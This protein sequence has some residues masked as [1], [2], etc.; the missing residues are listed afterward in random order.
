MGVLHLLPPGQHGG[1]VAGVLDRNAVA[2]RGGF[3]F[4]GRKRELGLL[5][6]AV[7][8]PPAVVLVEG[9]AGIGKSRL[10]HEATAALGAGEPVVLT[11]SC[12]PLR[13]PFPYGYGERQHGDQ[14]NRREHGQFLGDPH[15]ARPSRCRL[16]LGNAETRSARNGWMVA[17][18]SWRTIMCAVLVW[19]M[20][21]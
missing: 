16:P 14:R 7:R 8:R 3:A 15:R 18:R 11:G 12:H 4:V 10:V 5:L 17:A 13:E 20:T 21:R 1:C 9:E 2:H 19:R 6:A